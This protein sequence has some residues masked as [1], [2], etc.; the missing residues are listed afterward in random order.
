M[1]FM[2]FAL[3]TIPATFEERRALR[4]IGRNTERYQ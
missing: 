4:P 2:L 3:P 1:K